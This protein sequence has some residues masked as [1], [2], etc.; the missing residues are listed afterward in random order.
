MSVDQWNVICG[1]YE[2]CWSLSY[3]SVENFFTASR[4]RVSNCEDAWGISYS[5]T[6]SL[7]SQVRE[8]VLLRPGEWH[9]VSLG[10]EALCD[11]R[12]VLRY[13]EEVDSA[14]AWIEL[15][16]FGLV[17]VLNDTDPEYKIVMMMARWQWRQRRWWW[18][19]IYADV[20]LLWMTVDK[21]RELCSKITCIR[22][23]IICPC[24]GPVASNSILTMKLDAVVAPQCHPYSAVSSFVV[25]S[26]TE[27][28]TLRKPSC[29]WK[30]SAIL[31]FCVELTFRNKSAAF[32]LVVWNVMQF[33]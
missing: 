29:V 18:Y 8:P 26:D 31:S 3:S 16:F 10:Y 19:R 30:G 27:L 4:L 15:R 22:V 6:C 1:N 28:V 11:P 23:W 7:N 21:Q 25:V 17:S 32:C 24:V 33:T 2:D 12:S 13:S 9:P 5:L 14:H 20:N